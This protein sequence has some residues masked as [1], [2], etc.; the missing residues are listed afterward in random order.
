MGV[1][2][3]FSAKNLSSLWLLHCNSDSVDWFALVIAMVIS[4]DFAPRML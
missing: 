2:A 3:C 1:N 4:Y